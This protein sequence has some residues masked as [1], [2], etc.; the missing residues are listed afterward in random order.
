MTRAFYFI[1]CS[2]TTPHGFTKITKLPFTS[3]F[4][5]EDLP[6]LSVKTSQLQF[7]SATNRTNPGL[8]RTSQLS[9]WSKVTSQAILDT[10]TDRVNGKLGLGFSHRDSKQWRNL[11][12][13]NGCDHLGY[14]GL[15]SR[16]KRRAVWSFHHLLHRPGRSSTG[17][18]P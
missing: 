9:I 18:R 3:F 11:Q 4:I 13:M 16:E 15:T 5:P 7:D 6:K 14:Q 10:K 2:N 8:T 17:H 1:R 12:E